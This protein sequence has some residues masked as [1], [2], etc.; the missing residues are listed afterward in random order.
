M[1]SYYIDLMLSIFFIMIPAVVGWIRF[2]QINP[3]F[4]PFL[5]SIWLNALNVIFGSIIVQFGYY[6][7]FHYN[8]WFLIDAF[9][10][11]WLFKKWNLFESKKV[12][13]SLWVLLS[14]CWLA[15]SIFL[16]KLTRDYNSYFRIFYSFLIV[17][18]SIST[19][20]SLL[21][22]ERKPL[23]RNPMFII[24]C[25]LVLL[26]TITVMA[27]SFFAFNLQLGA[28]FRI[29]M[30]RMIVLTGLI[31]DLVYTLAILWM[32]K[33]QAFVLQY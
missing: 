6:N 30:E 15:E 1:D 20:N 3:V 32:P 22:R 31:C 12:Y 17:L 27:E 25:T 10:L 9:L 19:I 33:K 13:Y 7:I 4:Y 23:I 18:M 21:M 16:S 24:C 11:L 8:I 29:K 2:P 28:A 26:N 5:I 14:V